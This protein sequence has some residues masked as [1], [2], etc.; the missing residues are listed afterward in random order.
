MGG[1]EKIKRQHDAGRLTIRE[2]VDK[3]IDPDSLHEIGAIAGQGIYDDNNDLVELLPSNSFLGRARINGR[4]VVVVGDDFTVRGGSA[5]ATIKEKNIMAE[6]MANELRIPIVRLI[7]GSGGGG[8][9]KTIETRGRANLPGGVGQASGYHLI[10]ENMGMVPNVSLGLGPVAGLGAAR[11]AASHYS[12][13]VKDTSQLFVAGPPVVN[14][15]GYNLDRNELGDWKVQTQ[16]GAVDTAVDSEAEALECARQFLSYLPNSVYELPERGPITDDPNR[17]DE[18]LADVIPRDIRRVY[19]MRPIIKTVVDQGAFFEMGERFGPSIITGFARVDGWPVALMASDPYHYAGAWTADACMKITRFVDL[20]QTFH[21]PVIYLA[22][23]PG[24]LVGP[25]AEQTATIRHGV[26]AMAAIN[27]TDVPWCSFIIRNAFGVAGG[28]HQ[29]SGRFCVRYAWASARW[30]SLPLEG[31]IEAA[32]RAEIDDAPD[33]AAKLQEIETR[34]NKLR[35]PFRTAE[36]FWIEEIIDA[37]KTRQL[38]VEFANLAAPARRTGP[39]TFT[40]RP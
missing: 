12:V 10:A 23:C 15:I 37:R 36:T 7:E 20:A 32:Y 28:A 26:R 5:D 25:E 14:R 11:M 21:L 9:V 40:M 29:P 27:Q 24:F 39:S 2:R 16:C 18:S 22:D 19:K 4:P 33:P 1:E 34:L 8:S 38:M 13:M 3:L 17:V 30:G 35:S 6:R 31:G